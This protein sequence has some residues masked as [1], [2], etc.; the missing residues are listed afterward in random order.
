MNT[1]WPITKLF[2]KVKKTIGWATPCNIV[3][4]FLQLKHWVVALASFIQTYF[5]LAK[6]EVKKY[7]KMHILDFGVR[8]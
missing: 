7:L 3:S 5:N 4:L 6:F 2:S 1:I 8:A